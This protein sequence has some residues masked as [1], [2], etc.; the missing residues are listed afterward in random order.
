MFTI[1][2]KSIINVGIVLSA[3]FR[4]QKVGT[5]FLPIVIGLKI[6]FIF[7]LASYDI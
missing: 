4:G 6:I 1:L 5:V 7:V 2:Y 3:L